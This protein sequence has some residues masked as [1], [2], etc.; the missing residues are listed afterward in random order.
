[1]A[2]NLAA[3]IN[4]LGYGVVGLNVAIALERLGHEPALWPIGEVEAPA[5][6]HAALGRA[7][8]RR[9]SFDARAPSLRISYAADLAERVGSG[10]HGGLPVFELNRMSPGELAQLRALDI[11]FVA[12]GWAKRVL[13]D[14]GVAESRVAVAPFGVDRDIFRF[15]EPGGR[16]TTVF[17]N[18]GKWEMRKGHDVLA[19]A[20]SKAFTRAD[21]VRLELVPASPFS[22]EE[23]SRQW[24]GVYLDSPLAEKVRI[25]ERLPSQRDVAAVMAQAD[26]GVFPY[27]AEGWNLDLAEMLAM[28]KNVIATR[29]SAP[30][31]YLSADNARLIEIDRLED[32]VDGKW[33]HGQG[34]WAELGDAQVE[35]LVEHMRAVHRLKRA[36]ELRA[37][38]A[39]RDTMARFTWDETVRRLT[40]ALEARVIE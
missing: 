23:E 37:N 9:E 39:G 1:M 14:N 35:Q 2:F 27:R 7:L 5:E 16:G 24:A 40:A 31:E 6:H 25:F 13:T 3:P 33:F 17:L 32:A 12:S 11:V 38:I 36:G 10:P 22:S 28:G 15:V 29:Y 26:C 20:F 34:Q 8:A 18:V 19:E 4:S 21:D 30:T